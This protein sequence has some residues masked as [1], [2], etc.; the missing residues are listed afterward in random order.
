[1]IQKVYIFIFTCAVTRAVHQEV[2]KSLSISA[3]INALRRFV[4]LRF[5]PLT[6]YSDN[7]KTNLSAAKYLIQMYD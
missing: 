5:V 2:V 6:I 4:V 3:F 7:A 1:M